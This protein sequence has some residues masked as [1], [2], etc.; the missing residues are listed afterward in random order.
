MSNQISRMEIY[1]KVI[2]FIE[3]TND[4]ELLKNILIESIDNS[5]DEN[6]LNDAYFYHIEE[7]IKENNI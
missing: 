1:E 3:N 7:K 4:I 5:S 6:I 2:K